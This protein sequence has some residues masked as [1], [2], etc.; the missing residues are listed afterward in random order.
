VVGRGV[1]RQGQQQDAE[2]SQRNAD[3]PELIAVYEDNG[4]RSGEHDATGKGE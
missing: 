3:S 2:T 4:S 1:Q